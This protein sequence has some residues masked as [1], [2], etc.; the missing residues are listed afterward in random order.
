MHGRTTTPSIGRKRRC[1]IGAENKESYTTEW[2]PAHPHDTCRGALRPGQRVGDPR[3]L[4]AWMRRQAVRGEPHQPL[5]RNSIKW[6][7]S[8]VVYSY[9]VLM[10]LHYSSLSP[11]WWL[12]HSLETLA[13]SYVGIGELSLC[14]NSMTNTAGYCNYYNY[15]HTGL[16]RYCITYSEVGYQPSSRTKRDK[17]RFTLKSKRDIPLKKWNISISKMCIS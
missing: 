14:I 4:T 13:R 8:S 10:F 5:N 12:K 17:L 11:W 16:G 9:K 15:M 7:V 2:G 3:L 1:W 6:C